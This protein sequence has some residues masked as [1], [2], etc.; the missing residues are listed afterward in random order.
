VLALSLGALSAGL[1]PAA[2]PMAIVVLVA[3]AASSWLSARVGARRA[4]VPYD[5]RDM[6]AAPLY[7]SM[8]SLAFVHALWRL[9]RQPFAWDK[10]PHTPDEPASDHRTG[11]QAA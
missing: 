4:G 2:P 5:W 6:I 8:L 3:G 10:T 9:I 11:R 7:W 1:R